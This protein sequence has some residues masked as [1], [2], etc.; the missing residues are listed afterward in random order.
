MSVNVSA[1]DLINAA[2]IGVVVLSFAGPLIG[3][4]RSRRLR[5]QQRP[6]AVKR[7][8]R[9]V[10]AHAAA[11]KWWYIALLALALV[12]L[13]RAHI[14]SASF[15]P[16]ASGVGGHAHGRFATKGVMPATDTGAT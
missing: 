7:P 13:V 12:V 15:H 16:N 14:A 5:R 3:S 1:L 6:P 9:R 10:R 2:L 11:P 8:R 4:H